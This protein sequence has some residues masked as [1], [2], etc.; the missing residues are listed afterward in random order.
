MTRGAP[1]ATTGVGVQAPGPRGIELPVSG[2]REY[3]TLMR[4]WWF[5]AAVGT[6]TMIMS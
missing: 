4:Q 3:R 1:S 5:G 2:A 6:F